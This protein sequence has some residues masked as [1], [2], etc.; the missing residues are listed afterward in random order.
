MSYQRAFER[1]LRIGVVGVGDH[2]YRNLLPALHYLPLQLVALCDLD[3]LL[4][5]RTGAEYRVAA[6]YT[7]AESMYAEQALDA[8]LICAGPRYHPALVASAFAAGLHVWLEKPPAMNVA[9]V[10]AM[11][12]ARGDRVCA[13]GF[14]KAQ[15]PIVGCVRDLVAV[16]TS[17]THTTLPCG[18][19]DAVAVDV[20]RRCAVLT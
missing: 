7:D 12:A 3:P 2:A 11:I 18:G 16:Y 6:L 5:E 13:V 14:K 20:R 19:Q 8:V 17:D 15:S 9:G 1:L 4:L 10:D